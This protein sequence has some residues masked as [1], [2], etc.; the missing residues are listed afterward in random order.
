MAGVVTVEKSLGFVSGVEFGEFDEEATLVVNSGSGCV[1]WR[2]GVRRS[3]DLVDEPVVLLARVEYV[4]TFET[5][6]DSVESVSVGSWVV[7]SRKEET[8]MTTT[9]NGDISVACSEKRNGAVE[10]VTVGVVGND[11]LSDTLITNVKYIHPFT[12]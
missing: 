11:C 6:P 9:L 5:V 3:V 12:E 8:N 7:A 2:F 4:A 10:Y 1:D